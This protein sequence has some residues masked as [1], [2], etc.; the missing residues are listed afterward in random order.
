[1]YIYIC[2]LNKPSLPSPSLSHAG[3]YS[4]CTYAYSCLAL[5][6]YVR[7]ELVDYSLTN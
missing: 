2:I 3:A 4:D 1:M 6:K 7:I 5:Y